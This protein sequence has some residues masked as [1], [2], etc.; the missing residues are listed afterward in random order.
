MLLEGKWE[1]FAQGQLA[2]GAALVVIL[3][4]VLATCLQCIFNVFFHP[5][6]DLPGPPLAKISRL[7]A[8]IGNFY[9][10]K[11]KRI[12]AAHQ[13]YGPIVRVAPNE[14]SFAAPAAVHE[15][16]NNNEIFVKEEVF[17]RAKRIFHENHMMSFRD[18]EAH[19]QRRK[20][21]SRGFSQVSM[22]DFESNISDKIQRMFDQWAEL[23][24]QGPVDVYPW[25]HWLGFDI[26]YHLMFDEDP[27]SI[28]A[29]RPHEVMPYMRS[30]RPTFIY[31]CLHSGVGS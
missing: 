9:G 30:W 20:L 5:L 26:V 2:W 6:R 3:P 8:R 23:A 18:V 28:Q 12:H 10:C 25:V 27:G 19:K 17:Y 11:S 21:L 14:L 4:L 16:Y 13:K 15:I 31:V 7:W 22:L 29:G 1:L 24:S